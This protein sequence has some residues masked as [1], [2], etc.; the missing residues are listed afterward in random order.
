M[1]AN[2]RYRD[3]E[4]PES[5][6]GRAL[7]RLSIGRLENPRHEAF[8]LAYVRLGSGSKAARAAEIPGADEGYKARDIAHRLL[9]RQDVL[10]RIRAVARI[11]HEHEGMEVMELLAR[12]ARVARTDPRRLFD[13]RGKLLPVHELDE[14]GAASLAGFKVE[15]RVKTGADGE[16]EDEYDVVDIKLRDPLPALAL[17]AKVARL[18]DNDPRE[19]E[20]P[21]APMTE[22]EKLDTARRLAYFLTT[23]AATT[24]E[25][26]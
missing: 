2:K 9:D 16:I 14:I 4:L 6:T 23:A 8:A 5:Q 3:R 13:E 21:D 1:A 26:Q 15:H 19:Q 18:V 25:A 10:D 24:I 11:A 12:T 17:L 22:A 20:S 7:S